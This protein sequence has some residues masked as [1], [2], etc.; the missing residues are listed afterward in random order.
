MLPGLF[1][2]VLQSLT[3]G[4]RTTKKK[5]KKQSQ[6]GVLRHSSDLRNESSTNMSQD[7]LI[8]R[9]AYIAKLDNTLNSSTVSDM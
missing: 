6:D 1:H 8:D 5:K 7:L 4:P 3:Q 2:V 9:P